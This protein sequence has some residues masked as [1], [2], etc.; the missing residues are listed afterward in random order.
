MR[1]PKEGHRTP[2]KCPK[3]NCRARMVLDTR[4]LGGEGGKGDPAIR[5]RIICS[6]GHRY[7]TYERPAWAWENYDGIDRKIHQLKE[8]VRSL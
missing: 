4:Y 7:T 5:R 3:C 1:T 6:R 2:I 8:L